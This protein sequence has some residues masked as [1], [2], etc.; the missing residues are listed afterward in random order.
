MIA[1]SLQKLYRAHYCLT[2]VIFYCF[3]NWF[4]ALCD[5]S[6]SSKSELRQRSGM[7]T[8]TEDFQSTKPKNMLQDE[9]SGN[10]STGSSRVSRETGAEAGLSFYHELDEWQQDNHFIRYGY[11]KETNSYKKSFQSLFY[12]H[13]ETGNIYSHLLP[14]LIMMISLI[15]YIKYHLH[16]YEGH[17]KAWEWANFLQFGLA[18]NFCLAMSSIFHCLKSHSHGVSKFGN[19]LD[20]FGIVVLI[21]CSLISIVLFAYVDESFWKPCF[22][23]V[24][25]VLGSICTFFTLDPK[26]SSAV[27]RPIRSTM[28]IIFG[29]SGVLPVLVAVHKY[30]LLVTSERAG[31]PWLL[32]EGI[33]YI[34]GAVLYAIRVPERFTHVE[35]DETSLLLGPHVGKFDIWG[36]SHQIFH[37]FVVIAAYCHWRGLLA[38]YHYMHQV[39]LAAA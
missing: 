14:S 38:C 17:L 4:I 20:Y 36:H 15:Y 9:N 25:V 21:T 28:F 26:F 18:A 37:V 33:F 8:E 7:E 12:I 22:C 39:T 6:M 23:F 27:Y 35:E 2:V 1:K 5:C 34:S 31:L 16:T 32:L 30:G 3:T 11:V 19:Q 13:N 24:F 10:E 29:L